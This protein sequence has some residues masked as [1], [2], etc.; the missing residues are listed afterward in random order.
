M[1]STCWWLSLLSLA[2]TAALHG[3][4]LARLHARAD[5]LAREWRRANAVANAID[6]LERVRALAG[7]DTIRVGALTI[8]TNPSPLP[9]REAAARAWPVIDSLYGAEA[10]QLEQRPY[11]IVPVDPDTTVQRPPIQSGIE[12]TWDRDVASLTWL[13]LANVPI[14]RPDTGWQNWLGGPVLP[15]IQADVQRAGVYVQ[16]V[17][18]PSQAARRCFLGDLSGCRDALDLVDTADPLPRWYPSAPERRSLVLKSFGSYF[19]R[20]TQRPAL[21]ACARGSDSA[22][23]QLLHS[24]PP[25][26]L[27][28]PVTYDARA[29]LANLALR[30]GGR[31]AYHRLVA[32]AG[33]PIADRLVSAASVPVDS[34]LSRWRA[35]IL[36]AR[37][38]PVTLPARGVWV[39]LGWTALFTAC[40][41]RSSRWRV[42]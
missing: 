25:G 41:L 11:A 28:K 34:L 1:S 6:S 32:S 22:C 37:P 5:S 15:P 16:L 8:V 35:E 23:T 26:G 19:D 27:P 42:S 24:L 7:R 39:V 21:Q 14:G 40:G 18:A 12:I 20:E 31:E 38:R 10:H 4:S 13:L 3:Q 17:T 2:G 30:L 33:R 29:T 36:A 9:L